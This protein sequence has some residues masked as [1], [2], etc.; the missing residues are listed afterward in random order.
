MSVVEEI[1]FLAVLLNCVSASTGELTVRLPPPVQRLRVPA[2][3]ENAAHGAITKGTSNT[4][5]ACITDGDATVDCRGGKHVTLQSSEPPHWGR[6]GLP[7]K[8][9]WLGDSNQ[10]LQVATSEDDLR[11]QL[12]WHI[13]RMFQE[14]TGLPSSSNVGGWQGKH[15]L[16]LRAI[17]EIERLKKAI[18]LPA[19]AFA[20][21]S[22][23][24][25]QEPPFVVV[26]AM[27]ANVLGSGA[28]NIWHTHVSRRR[29]S[30]ASQISGVYYVS[31]G[32][33]GG[34]NLLLRDAASDDLASFETKASDNSTLVQ[35]A[36]DFGKIVLFPSWMEH[37]VSP[38]NESGDPQSPR[39]SIAFN[40]GA[41]WFKSAMERAIFTSNIASLQGLVNSTF[42][43]NEVSDQGLH[44]LHFAAEAG[45]LAVLEFLI[46]Q[47]SEVSPVSPDG[48]QPLHVAVQKG[49]AALVDSLL[50]HRADVGADISDEKG[51]SLHRAAKMGHLAIVGCLLDKRADVHSKARSRGMEPLQFADS[52]PIARR[53][54]E[55]R[56]S[57]DFSDRYGMQAIHYAAFGGNVD[58][59]KFLIRERAFAGAEIGPGIGY[60]VTGDRP[61]HLAASEDHLLVV[62]ALV[63]HLDG[64]LC[65][66]GYGGRLP[67][68]AAPPQSS[69][70]QW[71][72]AHGGQCTEKERHLRAS[73]DEGPII[74]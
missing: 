31:P 65:K 22:F 39:I 62:K 58:L 18:V 4:S 51:Q 60:K 3:S 1:L 21:R 25:A 27:W 32:N 2:W 34:A 42:E 49:H 10:I 46:D 9:Q 8:A 14:E 33:L 11:S 74:V 6:W 69:T 35:V 52:V 26:K 5:R 48:K 45:H 16:H 63:E 70:A 53:L 24:D 55:G 29:R 50:H 72:Y 71:L 43:A 36:P 64:S 61:I 7:D 41:R 30:D 47:R 38:N 40:L 12:E 19:Q 54:L 57:F 20:A 56:A 37:M 67:L 15:D 28:K 44:P 73:P 17:D 68:D 66:G 13:L 23:Q 59:V